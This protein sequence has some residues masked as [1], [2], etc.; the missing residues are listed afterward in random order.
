MFCKF[1]KIMHRFFIVIMKVN[2]SPMKTKRSSSEH[3]NSPMKIKTVS[4]E[5]FLLLLYPWLLF[6]YNFIEKYR[7]IIEPTEVLGCQCQ[8]VRNGHL[9]WLSAYL[10]FLRKSIHLNFFISFQSI[11]LER[12]HCFCFCKVKFDFLAI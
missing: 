11:G 8:L 7:S 4:I 5:E 1:F 2:F 10:L 9:S 12:R 6:L 3:I